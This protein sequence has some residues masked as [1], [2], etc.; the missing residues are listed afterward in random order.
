MS[1]H[2]INCVQR[3]CTRPH[4]SDLKVMLLKKRNTNK[5]KKQLDKLKK[6]VGMGGGGPK[7]TQTRV[8]GK[9]TDEMHPYTFFIETL[10]LENWM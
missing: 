2:N 1:V 10:L 3:L 7:S 8:V 5:Y 6:Q 9:V 4:P